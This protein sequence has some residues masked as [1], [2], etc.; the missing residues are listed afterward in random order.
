MEVEGGGDFKLDH[1]TCKQHVH[2]L[3]GEALLV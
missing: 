1:A 3:R 2:E